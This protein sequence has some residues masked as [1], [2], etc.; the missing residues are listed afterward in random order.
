MPKQAP[1]PAI[2]L[3]GLTV[4]ITGATGGLGK[5]IAMRFAYA[6]A[7]IVLHHRSSPQIA[8]DFAET[9][10]EIGAKT[11]I[12]SADIRSE[13]Q[14]A[15]IVDTA[16]EEFG[17]LDALVNNA[18]VQPVAPLEGMTVADWEA[19][20]N[21]NL[22]GTFAMTQAV[23][24]RMKATGGGSITHIAS[25]EA[26]LPAPN[27]AHYASSKAGVKMH[28]RAAA[29]ELGPANIR[30]NSVSPGLIDRGDLAQ[31][32]PQGRDSWLAAAPLGRTGTPDEIGDACVFLAS[33]LARW[34]TG[35]DLVVDGGM[36][37]VPAW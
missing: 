27:H 5:G 29:L 36:S 3:D 31:T 23:A 19:V 2:P 6:G 32:W 4:L 21:V 26:S 30:V 37:A 12:V 9:L 1:F 22:S 18:G 8:T 33:P 24:A 15:E 7:N 25:V 10:H 16:I 20:V 28:A 17:S 13:I 11:L 34:I 35:H 14:C